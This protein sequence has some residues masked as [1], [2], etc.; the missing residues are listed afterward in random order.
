MEPTPALQEDGDDMATF[1]ERVK[2]LRKEHKMSQDELAEALQVSKFSISAWERGLRKPEFSTLTDLSELFDVSMYYLLG[3]SD[4]AT[5]VNSQPNDDED[6]AAWWIDADIDHVKNMTRLYSRLSERSKRIVD[7]AIS[8]AY[9]MDEGSGE[10]QE[11]YRIKVERFKDNLHSSC[12][13][14]SEEQCAAEEQ[15][16][17]QE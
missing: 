16:D 3:A 17:A 10:L 13:D 8:A 14:G 7:G 4:D 15:C 12:D 2:A 9:K 1:A 6:G 5:S 11:G